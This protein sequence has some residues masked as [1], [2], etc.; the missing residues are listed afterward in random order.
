MESLELN[1]IQDGE[2][3]NDVVFNGFHELI[4]EEY[5]L[6]NDF[7]NDRPMRKAKRLLTR[8]TSEGD[9]TTNNVQ[10]NKKVLFM[11]KNCRK[12]RDGRGRGLPK[13]GLRNK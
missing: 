12:S 5:E 3:T 2:I 1:T 11:S 8:Q 13:K 4:D 9:N 6:D 10:I 7:S